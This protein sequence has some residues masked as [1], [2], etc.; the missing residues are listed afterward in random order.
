MSI[1]M[2]RR[3][4]A[5]QGWYKSKNKSFDNLPNTFTYITLTKTKGGYVTSSSSN[6]IT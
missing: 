3:K 1:F 6:S 2:E 5:K 4:R